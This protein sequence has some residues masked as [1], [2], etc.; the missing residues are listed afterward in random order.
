[1][2]SAGDHE[3]L[4]P[5]EDDKQGSQYDLTKD[6][7]KDTVIDEKHINMLRRGVKLAHKSK[8]VDRMVGKTLEEYHEELKLR[9][10]GK[11]VNTD[12]ANEKPVT[13]VK[14][15]VRKKNL[16][17][18]EK[19]VKRAESAPKLE[20]KKRN[21]LQNAPIDVHGDNDMA[22]VWKQALAGQGGFAMTNRL[23]KKLM[24]RGK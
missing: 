3:R 17:L 5:K 23:K 14:S 4:P 13:P 12:R 9:S 11:N 19:G 18:P 22:V 8:I 2:T 15:R 20:T 16:T 7:G 21:I 1:M 10:K 24:N 6:N